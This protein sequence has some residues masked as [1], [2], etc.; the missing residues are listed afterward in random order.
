LWGKI[1]AVPGPD[2]VVLDYGDGSY[3]LR[4][5]GVSIPPE[6][7]VQARQ[8]VI[9]RVLNKHARMWLAYRDKEGRMFVE[10]LTAEPG[11]KTQNVG[12]ELIRFGLASKL[13]NIND[14]YREYAAAAA[15][16][17]AEHRGMWA[18]H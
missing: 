14:K 15:E 7:A 3:E 11:V 5:V 2:T 16:A 8:F 10:L 9:N 13:D 1:T 17:R 4:I 18:N 6:L 12:V